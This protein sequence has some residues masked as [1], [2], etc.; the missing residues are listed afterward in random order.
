MRTRPVPMTSRT[1]SPLAD[2]GLLGEMLPSQDFA[3]SE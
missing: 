3:A 1:M 2:D